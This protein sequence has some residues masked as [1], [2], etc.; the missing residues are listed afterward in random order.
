M[1][2]IRKLKSV[3]GYTW[4]ALCFV[5]ILATFLG[6]NSWERLVA[7]TGIHVSPRFS[8]GETLRTIDHGTYRTLL[9]RPVFD[10]LLGERS[11]GFVQVDWV[12]REKQRLP[13]ILEEELDIDDNA[14]SDIRL[15]ADIVGGKVA[16][17][18]KATWVLAPEPLVAIG[19]ERILR[20]LL[21]NP[22]R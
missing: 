5:L 12:P 7:G 3:C 14:G 13:A 10:G 1:N 4:A 17:L 6:L 19:Q 16:L 9:H 2:A 18:Q 20:I 15:R 22:R 21:R 8:G 11:D